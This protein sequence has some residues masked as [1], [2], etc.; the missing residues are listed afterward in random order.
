MLL[1]KTT[2]VAAC[3]AVVA[4]IASSASAQTPPAAAAAPQIRHGAAVPGICVYSN[5]DLSDLS[6]TAKGVRTR[7]AQLATEAQ[8]ELDRERAALNKDITDFNAQAQTLALEV[9]EQRA[10]ALDVRQKQLERKIQIRGQELGATEQKQSEVLSRAVGP[11]V[12]QAYQARNCSVLLGGVIIG[13]PQM[14]ITQDV[15]RA[16]DAQL[17]PFSFNRENLMQRPAAAPAA[18]APATPPKK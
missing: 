11:L 3:T 6:V 18:A 8:G 2:A 17:K 9:R 15:A 4:A 1:K 7:L 16:L 12:I 14:D 13:N 5:G 10:N